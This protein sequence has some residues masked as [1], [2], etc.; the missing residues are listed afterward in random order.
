MCG[1]RPKNDSSDASSGRRG[2]APWLDSRDAM[3]V[4]EILKSA[5]LEEDQYEPS[6]VNAMVGFAYNYTK[7]ILLDARKI[8]SHTH[9]PGR[10]PITEEDVRFAVEQNSNDKKEAHMRRMLHAIAA[11]RNSIPLPAPKAV[12]TSGKIPLP[13]LQHC[14][15]QNNFAYRNPGNFIN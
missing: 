13:T 9:S 5:G 1:A 3:M 4:R 8:N 14:L 6:L 12:M 7:T 11:E 2:E 15:L 10:R